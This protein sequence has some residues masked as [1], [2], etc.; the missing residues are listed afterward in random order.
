MGFSLD[1]NIPMITIFLQ[2]L[3]SFFSPCILPLLPLYI[4]YLSAGA[5]NDGIDGD[6]SA[7][8]GR[9]TVNTLLFVLGV[10]FAFFL[11]GMGMT[12]L[13]QFFQGNQMFFARIGGILIFLFGMYQLGFLGKSS[14]L[15]KERRLPLR[16]DNMA[17]S[18]ITAWLM[19]FTFSF[20]WTPCV[21]PALASVLI[22]ASS[23]STQA[24]GIMLIGVYTLGFV[25]P[26]L[27]VGMFASTLLSFFK[28]HSNVVKYT[29]KIGG[30]LMLI[31]GA[32]MFTGK[33]NDVTG[34]LSAFPAPGEQ[35]ERENAPESDASQE[36]S[37][38][39]KDAESKAAANQD[40]GETDSAADA[41]PPA[42]D[43]TLTDQYGNTHTLS[44]YKG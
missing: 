23:A 29:V 19:G 27:A 33:M 21:G 26:F 7:N 43:F 10:S 20:A 13:G 3:V 41:L 38:Q 9:V 36:S 8:R 1:I 28:K 2:G 32:L 34:Y 39:T 22:M 12:A 35:K 24:A 6:S 25:L 4:G 14:I 37:S 40:A 15:E 18:P 44:D 31:M 17:M 42:I 30:V 11:L 16:L 5:K